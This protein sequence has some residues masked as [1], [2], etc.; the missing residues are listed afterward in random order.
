MTSAAAK[1]VGLAPHVRHADLQQAEYYQILLD[2]IRAEVNQELADHRASLAR[3]ERTG[4]LFGINRLHRL[5]R[6][7]ESELTTISQL[8]DALSARFPT[9]QTYS[10]G[11]DKITL[12]D[13]Y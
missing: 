2:E 12:A 8:T 1:V 9:S 11:A 7:K 4:H 3:R 13:P 5:I 6:L 10:P